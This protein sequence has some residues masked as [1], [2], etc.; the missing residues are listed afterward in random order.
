MY[1]PVELCTSA[2]LVGHCCK[3]RLFGFSLDLSSVIVAIILK[4]S[5]ANL[6][7]VDKIMRFVSSL[8]KCKAVL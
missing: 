3:T 1:A 5:D 8:Q 6:L 7:I 4:H 2:Y